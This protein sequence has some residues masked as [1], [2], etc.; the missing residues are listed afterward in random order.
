MLLPDLSSLLRI[1][2]AAPSAKFML[3]CGVVGGTGGS[4][5]D[6]TLLLYVGDGIILGGD[7][8]S[9]LLQ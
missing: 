3:N 6:D 7:I 8:L 4:D 2:E 1:A 5:G 9:S